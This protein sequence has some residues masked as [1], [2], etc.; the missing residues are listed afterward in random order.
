MTNKIQSAP[1]VAESPVQ[2]PEEKYF[3]FRFSDD[4][5][6]PIKV[7]DKYSAFA[8]AK[9]L[10]EQGKHFEFSPMAPRHEHLEGEVCTEKCRAFLLGRP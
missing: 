3:E 5:D 1:K 2:G 8:V 7:F 4:N 10:I 9:N 6:F